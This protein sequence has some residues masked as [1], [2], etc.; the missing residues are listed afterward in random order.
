VPIRAI[1]GQSSWFRLRRAGSSVV[2]FLGVWRARA[3]GAGGGNE[4][5]SGGGPTSVPISAIRGQT[6][7][8]CGA[9][10][11]GAPRLSFAREMSVDANVHQG[12]GE[13]RITR[14]VTAFMRSSRT[15]ARCSRVTASG[16]STGCRG[17]LAALAFLRPG[18]WA[19]VQNSVTQLRISA[20]AGSL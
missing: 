4:E 11:L 19:F 9:A 14:V 3:R 2:C 5:T 6:F 17:F 20:A 18:W 12:S 1:R 10:A 7:I 13:L 16:F 8:G 15:E